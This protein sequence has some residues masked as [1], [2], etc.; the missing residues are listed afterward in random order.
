MH[1][2]TRKPRLECWRALAASHGVGAA[3]AAAL[4]AGEAAPDGTP[5][6]VALAGV[7]VA[8]GFA[9]YP[10]ASAATYTLSVPDWLL[11]WAARHGVPTTG[12]RIRLLQLQAYAPAAAAAAPQAAGADAAAGG[13]Q[14]PVRT[15]FL[16][17]LA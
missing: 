8:R 12:G 14:P 11:A 10:E 9:S 5:L 13:A 6:W 3:A 1:V 4:A 16:P 15:L 2:I 7:V 17:V